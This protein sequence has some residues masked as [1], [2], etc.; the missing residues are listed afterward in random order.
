MD[1]AIAERIV[2]KIAAGEF[3]EDFCGKDGIPHRSTVWR[4]QETD[5]EFATQCAR[6]RE[7]SGAEYERRV[8]AAAHDVVMG[9]IEPDAARVA[10]N[11]LTWLCKVRAPKVYGDKVDVTASEGGF[12]LTVNLSRP[13]E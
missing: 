11:A 7:R 8:A 2:E 5:P 4:W 1:A 6:A 3:L 12:A 9:N 13:A 10:I